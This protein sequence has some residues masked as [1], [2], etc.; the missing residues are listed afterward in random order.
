MLSVRPWLYHQI[1]EPGQGLDESSQ[2]DSFII[3]IEYAFYPS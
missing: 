1:R 2:L 3:I